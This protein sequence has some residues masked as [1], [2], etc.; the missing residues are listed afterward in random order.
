MIYIEDIWRGSILPFLLSDPPTC[1][2]ASTVGSIRS[3]CH[4]LNNLLITW[5]PCADFHGYCLTHQ[6]LYCYFHRIVN[7]IYDHAIC[8]HITFESTLQ[9]SLFWSFLR[10]QMKKDQYFARYMYVVSGF[11]DC[12]ETSISPRIDVVPPR[13]DMG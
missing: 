7:T 10:E 8:H 12:C 3:T 5:N 6:P 1:E 9:R 2:N 4:F 11:K 13:L